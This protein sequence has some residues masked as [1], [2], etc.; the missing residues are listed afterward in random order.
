MG[1]NPLLLIRVSL[2]LTILLKCIEHR[3]FIEIVL[4]DIIVNL[5]D[6]ASTAKVISHN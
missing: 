4:V 6:I 5:K 2:L 1:K 3:L